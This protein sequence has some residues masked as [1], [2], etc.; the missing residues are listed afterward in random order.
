MVSR[1]VAAGAKYDANVIDAARTQLEVLLAH[2][3]GA[4]TKEHLDS[5]VERAQ[6]AARVSAYVCPPTEVTFEG[7]DTV[8]TLEE[9]GVPSGVISR[10]RTSLVSKLTDKDPAVARGALHAIFEEYDAWE[11]YIDDYNEEMHLAA[12]RLMFAIVGLTLLSAFLIW[13]GQVVWGLFTAGGAG[14]CLSVISK[15]PVLSTCGEHTAYRRRLLSQR[16]RSE[17]HRLGTCSCRTSFR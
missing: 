17:H 14:A 2:T 4:D 11:R 9:W 13:K 16:A 7:E 10:F 12:F 1:A 8:A 6:A 15:M 3:D 5:L